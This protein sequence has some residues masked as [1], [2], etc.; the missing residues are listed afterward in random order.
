MSLP[1][2]DHP[3]FK[4]T[5]P[6]TKKDMRFR[7]FLVKEEKILL[8]AKTGGTESDMILAIK[9]VVNNCAFD[10]M[11]VDKLAL[12]DLEYLF[13]KIRSQSVSNIVSVSYKD[14]EDD[15]IYDFQVDLEKVE[16]KYP[17][18]NENNIKTGKKSGIIMKYPEAALYEDKS[19]LN[20][21]DSFYQLIL[22]CVDK[23][24][25][26]DE[27]YDPKV[28]S[29]EEISDYVENLS[30]SVFEQVRDYLLNQPKL[31]H[32]I[33]YKNSLGNDRSIELNTLSDFFTLR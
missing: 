13:L 2:I 28:Y 26:G 27:V 33:E 4:L 5:I 32:L 18:K 23:I 14:Y 19:F 25:D 1:K 6:S 31:Y 7:P 16:I 17:D 22:R 11:D 21:D 30:V 9:Q 20:A 29:L 10:K 24:Y 15:K 3:V 12:F 8:M